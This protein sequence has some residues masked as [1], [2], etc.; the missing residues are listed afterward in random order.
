MTTKEALHQLIDDMP[1][2]QAEQLMS[3]L[4]NRDPITVSLALAPVDDE[5]ETLE[6][7]AAVREAR[8][9]VQRGDLLTTAEL[10]RRLGL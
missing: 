6:E 1:D 3:G 8:E 10:R 7:A 2:E 5:P 9:A 4:N